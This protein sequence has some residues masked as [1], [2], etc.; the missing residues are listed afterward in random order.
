MIG[1]NPIVG[2]ALG[3]VP[4]TQGDFL[5]DGRVDRCLVGDDLGRGRPV[6]ECAG[7]ESPG[8]RQVPLRGRQ[9]VDHLPTLVDRPVQIHPP[10]GDLEI[11]FVN[12]PAI[13]RDVSAR[14][15][16]VDEQ[17]CL[18]LH[19]AVDG[20]MIDS[21]P[22]ISQQLFDVP[23][24]EPVPETPPDRHQDHLRREPETGE[25]SVA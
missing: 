3:V 6:L 12:E 18:P 10:S 11:R 1:F 7:K 15:A 24:G 14:P 21:D 4:G 17:Q 9:H 22:A 23:I 25:A 20:H 16:R 8:R 5:E 19:P 13:S 2:V